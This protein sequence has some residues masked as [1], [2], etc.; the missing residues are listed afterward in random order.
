MFYHSISIKENLISGSTRYT[1][2][3]TVINTKE[4]LRSMED[5][6]MPSSTVDL[7]QYWVCGSLKR[8]RKYREN[9]KVGIIRN[10]GYLWDGT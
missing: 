4:I 3:R 2:E 9:V 1:F 10:L 5:L 7:P 8:N 6:K